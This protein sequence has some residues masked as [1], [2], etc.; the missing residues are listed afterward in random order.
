MSDLSVP[1]A[2]NELIKW[3]E[4]DHDYRDVV[5]AVGAGRCV[6]N[7]IDCQPNDL[8]YCLRFIRNVIVYY[9]PN[10]IMHVL[11]RKLVENAV[12]TS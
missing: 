11:R 4:S 10:N 8:M 7:F 6:Q 9:R 2:F 1:V 3:F 12:W 5:Q